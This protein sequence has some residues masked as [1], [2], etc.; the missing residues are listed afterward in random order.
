MVLSLALGVVVGIIMGLTGA[1]GSILAVGN[2]IATG[3][4]DLAVAMPFAAAGAAGMGVGTV[5]STRLSQKS[6]KL[7]FAAICAAVSIGMVVNSVSA[8]TG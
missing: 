3:Q 6:L 5:L 2:S 1:G 8:M 7:S 4:L